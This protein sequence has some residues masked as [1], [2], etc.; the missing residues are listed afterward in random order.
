MR[1]LFFLKNNSGAE[2]ETLRL[3]SE[4]A[5]L[6]YANRIQYQGSLHIIINRIN[7]IKSEATKNL[8]SKG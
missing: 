6:Y 5:T 4:W 8:I 2:P 1:L 3:R 7:Q